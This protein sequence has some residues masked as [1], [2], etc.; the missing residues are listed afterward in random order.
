MIGTASASRFFGRPTSR[1]AG[2]PD[3]DPLILPA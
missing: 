2:P 1:C 3:A